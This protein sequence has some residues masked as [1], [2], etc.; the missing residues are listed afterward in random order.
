MEQIELKW[1]VVSWKEMKQ[2]EEG[3]EVSLTIRVYEKHVWDGS[4]VFCV[5]GERFAFLTVSQLKRFR[6]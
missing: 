3:D 2:M 4:A 1:N 6:N 5:R